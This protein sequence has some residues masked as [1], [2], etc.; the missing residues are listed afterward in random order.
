MEFVEP[1]DI[2]ELVSQE[3]LHPGR[4]SRVRPFVEGV[5]RHVLVNNS[6]LR[7]VENVFHRAT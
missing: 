7:E 2:L 6:S 4:M 1:C 3:L 5:L